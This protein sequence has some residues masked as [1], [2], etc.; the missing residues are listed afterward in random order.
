MANREDQSISN[1]GDH[2]GPCQVSYSHDG[3]L[4]SHDDQIYVCVTP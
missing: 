3:F 4:S 2:Q 1:A